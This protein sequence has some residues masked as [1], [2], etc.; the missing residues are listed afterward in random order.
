MCVWWVT[1]SAGELPR[2]TFIIYLNFASSDSKISKNS[3]NDSIADDTG[4]RREQILLLHDTKTLSNF[5][6]PLPL[7]S[8]S[9]GGDAL[10]LGKQ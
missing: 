7:L 3:E 10:Q 9:L 2:N 8:S 5:L 1:L 6:S 4:N